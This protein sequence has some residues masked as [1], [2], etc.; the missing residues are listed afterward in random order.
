MEILPPDRSG[1]VRMWWWQV[2]PKTARIIKIGAALPAIGCAGWLFQ[3]F[4]QLRGVVNLTASRIDLALLALCIV[5]VAYVMTVGSPHKIK[6]R[7]I[8]FS[9]IACL[10]VAVDLIT[11]KPP[12]ATQQQI[13]HQHDIQLQQEVG[14][15]DKATAKV[16][17]APSGSSS[18]HKAA[19][20]EIK[21]L[22]RNDGIDTDG[23][24][25]TEITLIP[26]REVLAPVVIEL[27]FHAPFTFIRTMVVPGSGV[28]GIEGGSRWNGTKLWATI[29][30][31]GI[32]PDSVWIAI[33]KSQQLIHLT[34]PPHLQK[35]Y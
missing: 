23:L 11:P 28:G 31:T 24:V 25:I 7:A 14:I 34:S 6:L 19:P 13:V 26:N 21:G 22:T 1:L 32:S 18:G 17:R 2:Q 33:V 30:N 4:L 9:I 5:F 16:L 12:Q 10:G 20:F 27:D 35:G 3:N 29:P 8:L 15:S